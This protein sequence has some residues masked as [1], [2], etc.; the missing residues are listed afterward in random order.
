MIFD[1]PLESAILRRRYKRF[2]ADV[3]RPDGTLMTVHCPNSGSM[4]TCVGDGWS[5]RISDSRNPK[6]KL[7]HTLEM[8]HNGTCW[9]GVN[10]QLPNKI[11]GEAIEAGRI[12]EL[13]GYDNLQ[14]EVRYGA[15]KSRIDLLA[16]KPD[17]SCY[18]EVKNVTLVEEDGYYR[19]PDAVTAR[20]LKHLR[21]LMAMKDAGHR[22]VMLYV[23][24]RSDG[25]TFRPATAIDPDYAAAL[26]TAHD[27]GVEILPYLAKVSPEAVDLTDQRVPLEWD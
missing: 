12:P 11:A 24:Q 13:T 15:E 27:H 18:I 1:H 16:T 14:R 23:I 4:K 22:A 17:E 25:T 26:K 10:T 9:I 6:R 19:F 20:G 5:C 7:S 21:E 2:L 3:E 8:V